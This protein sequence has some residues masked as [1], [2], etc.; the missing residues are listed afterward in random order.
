M[1]DPQ[2]PGSGPV[3]AGP[4][5]YVIRPPQPS[6]PQTP[7]S[8]PPSAPPAAAPATTG[9]TAAEPALVGGLTQ[10]GAVIG[11]A[12]MVGLAI[13]F[14]LLRGAVR[15]HLIANRASLSAANG[16]S[17]AL[18]AFLFVV[19]FTVV[20]GLIGGFWTVL[21]F[22]VPFGLL[23]LITLVLFVILFSSATRITR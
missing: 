10:N 15:S 9:T 21:S 17:W 19:G 3:P 4:S 18:F 23:S 20:F 16:A 6:I 12:I 1:A 13:V 5:G 22:V 7:P 8:A 11:A 2:H 14:F